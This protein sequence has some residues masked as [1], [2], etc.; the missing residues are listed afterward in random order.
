MKVNGGG[1][2][3]KEELQVGVRA[4]LVEVVRGAVG[5]E[6]PG[7][8]GVMLLFRVK[9]SGEGFQAAASQAR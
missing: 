3:P 5:Q 8:E 4:G 6:A 9:G 7:D 1:D 2:L